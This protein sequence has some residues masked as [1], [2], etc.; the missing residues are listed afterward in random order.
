MFVTAR[1]TR[2]IRILLVFW[3]VL[4]EKVGFNPSDLPLTGEEYL[5]PIEMFGERNKPPCQ[6]GF[7][8]LGMCFL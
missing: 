3:Q 6:R 4:V 8:G 1:K 2:Y 7:G 5:D